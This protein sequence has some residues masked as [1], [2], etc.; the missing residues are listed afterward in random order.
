MSGLER[1]PAPPPHPHA[2]AVHAAL[3]RLQVTLDGWTWEVAGDEL[4]V[5]AVLRHTRVSL[6]I[7]CRTHTVN[8]DVWCATIEPDV[9]RLTWLLTE[10][11]GQPY[12]ARA[13][14]AEGTL[15]IYLTRDLTLG[16]LD[17]LPALVWDAYETSLT[18]TGRLHQVPVTPAAEHHA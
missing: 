8:L 16:A 4:I 11:L 13:A 9:T 12:T 18:M 10:T 1:Y 2:G 5:V 6:R 14:R 17:D 15:Q 7:W 3:T